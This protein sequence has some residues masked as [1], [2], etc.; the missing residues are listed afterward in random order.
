MPRVYGKAQK[1][2]KPEELPESGIIFF[3]FGEKA[4]NDSPDEFIFYLI[5]SGLRSKKDAPNTG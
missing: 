1:K 3:A 4:E 5:E 2:D